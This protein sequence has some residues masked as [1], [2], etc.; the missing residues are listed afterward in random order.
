[1]LKESP[2]QSFNTELFVSELEQLLTIWDL[3][4][5]SYSKNEKKKPIHG[6]HCV[7]FIENIDEKSSAEKNGVC[8][9]WFYYIHVRVI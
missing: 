2:L 1:M 9:L 3:R 7:K 4:S 8:M 6:R 5:P